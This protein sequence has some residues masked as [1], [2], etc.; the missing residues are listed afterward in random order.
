[1][2]LNIVLAA[3]LMTAISCSDSK[4]STPGSAE[5][6]LAG[7]WKTECQA[8]PTLAP[9]G[10]SYDYFQI[11]ADGSQNLHRANYISTDCSG[12]A[13]SIDSFGTNTVAVG[14]IVSQS[15]WT[16]EFDS[17]RC[18]TTTYLTAKFDSEKLYIAEGE[19]GSSTADRCTDFTSSPAYSRMAAEDVP[20]LPEP[21]S[22]SPSFCIQ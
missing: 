18:N 6:D 14:N 7:Y 1:M 8:A 2:S 10:S 11:T 21:V 16:V 22:A 5:P 4:K 15:P 17:T 19:C 20:T 9:I 3:S 12:S 13:S